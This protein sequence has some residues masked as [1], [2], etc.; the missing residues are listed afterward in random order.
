MIFDV[1]RRVRVGFPPDD[2]DG[3]T[4]ADSQFQIVR[5]GTWRVEGDVLIMETNNKPLLDLIKKLDPANPP[6]FEAKTERHKIVKI[7]GNKLVFEDGG[8]LSRIKRK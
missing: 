5:A 2:K 7:D 6:P 1:N 4:I 3:R 8:S